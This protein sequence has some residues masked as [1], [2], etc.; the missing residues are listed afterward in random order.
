MKRLLSTQIKGD[1][2]MYLKKS[3]K[4]INSKRAGSHTP[5][6]QTDRTAYGDLTIATFFSN[7]FSS[8][9]VDLSASVSESNSDSGINVDSV[10]ISCYH[11]G[12][13][14]VHSTCP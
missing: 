14:N 11:I 4:F 13:T 2:Q 9:F 1:I 7:Y 3:R 10:V 12:E 8:V 6:K 5:N